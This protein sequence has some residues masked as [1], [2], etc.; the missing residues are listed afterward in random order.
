MAEQSKGVVDERMRKMCRHIDL[1]RPSMEAA[2]IDIFATAKNTGWELST[3]TCRDIEY[4]KV[5][6][7][8]IISIGLVLLE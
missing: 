4:G 3:I 2:R 7:S 8:N 5:I 6:H 1:V